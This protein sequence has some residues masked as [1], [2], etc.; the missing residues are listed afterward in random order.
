M[1]SPDVARDDW[2]FVMTGP[3]EETP[4]RL[5]FESTLPGV[6]AVGDVRRDSTKRV[7]SAV[8]E[9][10]VCVRLVHEYLADRV[11]RDPVGSPA[12]VRKP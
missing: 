12:R 10:A 3:S 4:S 1:A 7:A 9:G 11:P 6:F 2:G 8:G 5:P